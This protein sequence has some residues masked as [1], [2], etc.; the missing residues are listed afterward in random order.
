MLDDADGFLAGGLFASD[1]R[2]RGNCILFTSS[3]L[4]L[5]RWHCDSFFNYYEVH[6]DC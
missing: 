3:G 5:T 6:F 2:A 1:G 4:F